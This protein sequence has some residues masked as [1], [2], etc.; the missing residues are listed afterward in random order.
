MA[1]V[2]LGASSPELVPGNEWPGTR[3]SH[4]FSVES[5]SANAVNSQFLRGCGEYMCGGTPGGDSIL[6]F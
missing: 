4:G 5:V 1:S 3:S 6:M 2:A